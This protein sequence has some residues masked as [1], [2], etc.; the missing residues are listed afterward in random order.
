[1]TK[2]QEK[3]FVIVAVALVIFGLFYF[4]L[5]NSYLGYLIQPLM[6]PNWDEIHPKFIVKNS[7]MISLVE[8]EN[9]NCKVLAERFGGITAHKFF[10]KGEELVKKLNFDSDNETIVL[11]CDLLHGDQSRLHI[12]YVIDESPNDQN[13]Y[14]Y[15][16]TELNQTLS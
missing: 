2:R 3:I 12:W 9:S 5:S 10:I 8:K 15:F 14:R 4:P 16:V 7:V 1:M 11:P 6:E 13:K